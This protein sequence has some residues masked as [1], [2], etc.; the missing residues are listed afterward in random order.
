METRIEQ[1][2]PLNYTLAVQYTL[3]STFFLHV[4][5][6]FHPHLVNSLVAPV[7]IAKK[8]DFTA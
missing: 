5:G 6:R 4:P 2:V 3:Q 1:T 8:P 7:L